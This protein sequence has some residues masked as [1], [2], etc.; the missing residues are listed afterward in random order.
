MKD[1]AKT[2]LM[3]GVALVAA[4]VGAYASKMDQPIALGL[5]MLA[6]A[7]LTGSFTVCVMNIGIGVGVELTG[8]PEQDEEHGAL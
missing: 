4:S 3:V 1:Y 5:L 2:M 6:T 8:E 7:A